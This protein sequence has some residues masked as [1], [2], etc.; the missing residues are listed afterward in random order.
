MASQEIKLAIVGG[1]SQFVPSIMNG[2]AL[3]MEEGPAF[4]ARV[5][6]YD[7]RPEAAERMARYGA[8]VARARG[9]PLVAASAGSREE[10]LE[11][12]GL[13]LLS[14]W[15][16]QEHRRAR[17]IVARAGIDPH[18]DG[19]AQVADALSLAPFC[20]GLGADMRR[21]CPG[22]LF[23]GLVNPT[24]ILPAIIEGSSGVRSV[25]L[26]VEVEGLRGLLAYHLG[27]ERDGL[28][29][30]HV[31]VNHDGWVLRMRVGERDVYPLWQAA[32]AELER[33]PGY[34]PHAHGG[35]A[36]YR[37]TGYLRT[38]P[39]HNLPFRCEHPHDARERMA[40][41]WPDKRRLYAQALDRALA[42]GMPIA[43]PWPQHPERSPLNYPGT[44][45]Q[46]G[47]LAR[48]LATGQATTGPL[49]VRNGGAVPN[50][51]AEVTVEVPVEAAG[52]DVRPV[53]VGEAPE[54]LCGA[55]RLE[56]IQRRMV[57][58][59]AL[60]R[61]PALL[62]QALAVVPWMADVEGLAAY[63]RELECAYGKWLGEER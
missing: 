30:E 53:A 36:M 34:H 24:D 16:G 8:I 2:L 41:D 45:R 50:W 18:D 35:L 55:A 10:A 39:Y 48:A 44:G 19:L 13:V 43:D 12:A 61:D 26:C 25:G 31:G 17:E 20:F 6:L 62:R 47:R 5:A 58:D 49:Q 40:A 52:R 28:Q 63:A 15:L 7:I 21:L 9:L 4:A 3:A 37:L 11:G 27:L 46:I 14:A 57:A 60:R 33:D 32:A 56:A 29:L 22:T 1:G 51:P 42:S 23:A 54:W 59:Y 38:S